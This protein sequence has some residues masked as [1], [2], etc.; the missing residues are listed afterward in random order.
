MYE[1]IDS[2]SASGL[3]LGSSVLVGGRTPLGPLILSFGVAEG[4]HKAAYVQIG[5]PLKER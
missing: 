5:R 4:G 1:R 2:A 3:L